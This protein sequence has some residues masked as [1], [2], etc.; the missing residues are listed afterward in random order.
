MIK[1][2]EIVLRFRQV[3]EVPASTVPDRY[4]WVAWGGKH[5]NFA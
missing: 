1:D 5:L 2:C 3:H 4:E